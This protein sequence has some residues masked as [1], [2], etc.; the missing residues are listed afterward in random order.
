MAYSRKTMPLMGKVL[1][2][3]Q[4]SA[5]QN[6]VSLRIGRGLRPPKFAAIWVGNDK[7]SEIYLRRKMDAATIT[8]IKM[9]LIHYEKPIS[10]EMMHK[11][12]EELNRCSE[13]DGIIVQL[14]LPRPLDQAAATSRVHW[15]KDVDGFHPFN[16]G[17]MALGHRTF[18]PA[19]VAG[20]ISLIDSEIGIP[21]LRRKK[22]CIVGRSDHICKPLQMW[23]QSGPIAQR[24]GANATCIIVHEETPSEL[25][26][27]EIR[28]SDMVVTAT[29]KNIEWLTGDHIKDGAIIIDVAFNQC[30]NT[31]RLFGDC[32]VDSC[33]GIASHIT[34]VPGG[35]GPLTV[36]ELM[37]NVL[38]A[39]TRTH[40]N[41]YR[42]VQGEQHFELVSDFT[43]AAM[44]DQIK[45]Q[46]GHQNGGS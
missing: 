9:D 19:T 16:I 20:I 39:S 18:I 28:T 36:S 8:G 34:P 14:P 1:A 13:T 22:V 37:R 6:D 38:L 46:N 30:P 11:K 29:G 26:F 35:V 44:A 45:P 25:L 4:L 40:R 7:A 2:K 12:I 24:P 31:G 17:R 42:K 43:D 41:E 27:H 5:V 23:L 10:Q 15:S 21:W 3:K 33:Y 32:H